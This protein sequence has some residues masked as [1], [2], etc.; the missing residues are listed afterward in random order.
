[1]SMSP[2]A[3]IQLESEMAAQLSNETHRRVESEAKEG[4][5]SASFGRMESDQFGD[6]QSKEGG[7]DRRI[8]FVVGAN[9]TERGGEEG[10]VLGFG[11]YMAV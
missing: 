9:V 10:I 5:A 11:V 6:A 1:M 7:K 4:G 8:D 3:Q 2:N